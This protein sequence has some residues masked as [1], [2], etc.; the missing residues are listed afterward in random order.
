MLSIVTTKIALIPNASIPLEMDPRSS[1]LV[2]LQDKH[3]SDSAKHDS[4]SVA[5]NTE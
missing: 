4:R 1:H 5:T 2:P 3:T